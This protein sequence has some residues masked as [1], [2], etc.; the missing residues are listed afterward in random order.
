MTDWEPSERYDEWQG[1]LGCA[2]YLR[3][4]CDAYPDRIPVNSLSGEVDHM[5]PRPYQVDEIVFEP[6]DIEWWRDTG[7]RRPA[8]AT[9]GSRISRGGERR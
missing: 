5:V 1:C 6:M 9:F 7:E 3:G 8:A 2:R 4:R